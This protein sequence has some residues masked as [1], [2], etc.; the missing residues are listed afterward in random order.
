MV[1]FSQGKVVKFPDL[2]KSKMTINQNAKNQQTIDFSSEMD[3]AG[4]MEIKIAGPT[5]K[6]RKQFIRERL[7]IEKEFTQAESGLQGLE[8][9]LSENDLQKLQT[10]LQRIFQISKPNLQAFKRESWAC[11]CDSLKSETTRNSCSDFLK[12]C[13]GRTRS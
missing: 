8:Q 13:R 3:L 10:L 11:K 5:P 6:Q 7:E 1:C 4:R 9:Q 12:S 2:F